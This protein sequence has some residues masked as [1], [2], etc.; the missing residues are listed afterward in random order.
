M[1]LAAVV[2]WAGGGPFSSLHVRGRGCRAQELYSNRSLQPTSSSESERSEVGDEAPPAKRA[3]Q[4]MA[5]SG[6]GDGGEGFND[7]PQLAMWVPTDMVRHALPRAL[8]CSLLPCAATLPPRWL[9]PR[10]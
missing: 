4:E 9:R 1:Q 3:R 8:G 10:R 5:S 2:L 6:G 7:F